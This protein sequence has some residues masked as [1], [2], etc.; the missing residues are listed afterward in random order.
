[1]KSELYCDSGGEFRLETTL[2]WQWIK[3]TR[4]NKCDATLLMGRATERRRI[5]W[6][7][8]ATECFT[9]SEETEKERSITQ[10]IPVRIEGSKGPERNRKRN[11]EVALLA[12]INHERGGK[13]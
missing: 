2:E 8:E 1:M 13:E 4:G 5:V 7:L 11:I 6:K 3:M 10:N 9:R 12:N